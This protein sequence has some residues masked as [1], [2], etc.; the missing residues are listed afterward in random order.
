M[1]ALVIGL[2]LIVGGIAF[3]A[4]PLLRRQ[5]RSDDAHDLAHGGPS[6]SP[7][8]ATMP[9]AGAG[10]VAVAAPG[11]PHALAAELEELELDRAMG[12]LSDADYQRLR[13]D[14]LR[15][16]SSAVPVEGE[17]VPVTEADIAVADAA[18]LPQPHRALD[19]EAE[20]LVQQ[21]ARARAQVPAC[22]TCGPRP[23]ADSRFCSRCG[24]AL[25][26][27]PGCGALVRTDAARFCD[28]CGTALSA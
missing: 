26:G 13:A 1:T 3:A 2:V 6:A 17:G 9:A 23:E 7:A 20:R 24:R 10:A 18:T 21:A 11:A 15:R 16:V 12:K 25:G 28:Q 8:G 4:A 5:P 14:V 27:C 19:E 22:G